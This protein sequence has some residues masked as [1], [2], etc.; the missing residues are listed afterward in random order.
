MERLHDIITTAIFFILPIYL[1]VPCSLAGEPPL[2][3][4]TGG[5][6]FGG[7]S[8]GDNFTG[9]PQALRRQ[10]VSAEESLTV[11]VLSVIRNPIRSSGRR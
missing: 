9:D 7:P 11:D 10:S 1:S 8:F 6:I 2:G 5:V 3:N 4:S